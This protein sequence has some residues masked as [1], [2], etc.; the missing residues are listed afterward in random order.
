VTRPPQG[1]H[2]SRHGPDHDLGGY[3][4]VARVVIESL[5]AGG[6]GVGRLPDG[7]TVFVPRTAPGDRVSLQALRRRRRF[8]RSAV[9]QVLEPG[10]G[11]VEPACVH[12]ARDG[13]GGCQWQHLSADLQAGAKRRIVGDALRRIGGLA[14]EDPPLVP[15]PHAYGYR[16]TLTLT[17]RWEHEAPVV[18]FHH[19]ERTDRVFALERCEVAR[20]EIRTL[21][22]ALTPAL[23]ALPRGADV[24]LKLRVARDGTRHVVVLGGEGAWTGAPPL[25]AAAA[26][27]AA[28]VWWQPTGG[29]ARRLAGPAA[30]RRALAFEQVNTGVAAGLLAAI[31][32]SVPA[33]SRRV[34]DLYAGTGE[35]GLALAGPGREVIAVEL[36]RVAAGHAARR[37]REDGIRL[38]VLAGRVE[39]VI[40]R[41]LPADVVIANPPRTGLAPEASAALAARPPD[42]LLYVSCDPATL[43]RDLKRLGAEPARL[44]LR[45][46]DMFPQTSHVE[47]LAVLGRPDR[48]VTAAPEAAPGP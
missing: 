48:C 47:T 11:R 3:E 6:D 2:V 32:E 24:R 41:L 31:L 46:Y 19:G 39:D 33:D 36:D 27:C 14:V 45:C 9:R 10:P 12:F 40:A 26:G 23:G 37:A 44:R 35:A 5:A 43:A 4:P 20:E 13:C 25:A 28:T 34:L 21:W 17:V 38:E 42:R 18:G 7:M 30:D 15:S 8:A 1:A 29:V 22:S 16:A